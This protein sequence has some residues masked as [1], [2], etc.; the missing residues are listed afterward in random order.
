MKI[1]RNWF[2][3]NDF[4]FNSIVASEGPASC[5]LCAITGCASCANPCCDK[6][7]LCAPIS[8][9]EGQ[10]Y[11]ELTGLNSGISTD[12]C[13]QDFSQ[14]FADMATAILKHNGIDQ[15]CFPV[16]ADSDR[17]AIVCI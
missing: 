9:D 13:S 17:Y 15:M 4:T 11:H 5:A 1:A 14:A 2:T 16:K 10:V 12:L 3:S 7:L 6:A 8:S